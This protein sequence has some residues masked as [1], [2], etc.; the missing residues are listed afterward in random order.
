[1]QSSAFNSSFLFLSSSMLRLKVRISS[2]DHNDNARMRKN[3]RCVKI[4][5]QVMFW[6]V[7]ASNLE[8]LT[9]K[10]EKNNLNLF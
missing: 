9:Q 1:M 6:M 10:H 4:A 2:T 5:A 3:R 7:S 8:I